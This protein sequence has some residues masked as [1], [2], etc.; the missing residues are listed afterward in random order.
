MGVFD[1]ETPDGTQMQSG[2]RIV[3]RHLHMWSTYTKASFSNYEVTGTYDDR[4]R[5]IHVSS[6]CRMSKAA[7]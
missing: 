3:R 4:I 5:R 2:Y 7:V 6:F 1:A